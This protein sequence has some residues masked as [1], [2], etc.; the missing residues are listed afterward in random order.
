M[1]NHPG[2]FAFGLVFVILGA[3]FL[4]DVYDVWNIRPIRL[5]PVLLIAVGA[6]IVIG[7]RKSESNDE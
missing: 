7:G 2:T 4:L 3:A 6:V 1:K 5:W